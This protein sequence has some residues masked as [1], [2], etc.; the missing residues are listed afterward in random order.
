MAV[1]RC[2]VCIVQVYNWRGGAVCRSVLLGFVGERFHALT[3]LFL[4]VS[5]VVVFRTV[6]VC[7]VKV[8]LGS[9]LAVKD[10][11]LAAGV[12]VT[13]VLYLKP[14]EQKNFLIIDAAMNDLPRPAMYQAFH[15][16]AP[17][18]LRALAPRAVYEVVGPICE[19]GDWIGHD[20]VL[21]VL[22][23]GAYCMG[24]A[25]NYNSR[26][27]AAEVLVDGGKAH[28]IRARESITDQMRNERLV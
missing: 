19:S 25:S 7:D 10:D 22:S 17:L 13:E 12:C 26:G 23:A 14:G 4:E 11:A 27:R 16:I 9:G 28:L 3:E 2:G 20:R 24:M 15:D 1:K 18:D 8:D 6:A 5:S 21:A